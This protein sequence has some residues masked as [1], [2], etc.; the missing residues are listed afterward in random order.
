MKIYYVSDLHVDLN[1][2]RYRENPPSDAKESIIVIAG[3]VNTGEKGIDSITRLMKVLRWYS[4]NF[5]R[6]IFIAG[7]HEFY[8]NFI[9]SHIEWIRSEVKI[10]KLINVYILDY[11]IPYL[12]LDGY[13]FWGDTLWSNIEGNAFNP[14]YHVQLTMNIADFRHIYITRDEQT[15]GRWTPDDMLKAYQKSYDSL[16]DFLSSDLPNKIVITHF[17]PSRQSVH[18]RF[19]EDEL[20]LNCYFTNNLD[21]LIFKYKPIAWIHG[22]VH[23]SFNYK[24]LGTQVVANPMGYFDENSEYIPNAFLSFP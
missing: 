17:A 15:T 3:D 24:I 12:E 23:N 13:Y 11:T 18:S 22:H 4:E 14:L 6:V 20:G 2:Q 19:K 16:C 1:K 8:G 5:L 7:N 9:E 21:R 10:N